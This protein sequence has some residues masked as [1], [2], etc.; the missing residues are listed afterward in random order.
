[1]I[2]RVC[3]AVVLASL[4]AVAVPGSVPASAAAPPAR[5]SSQAIWSWWSGTQAV[6]Q[7]DTT[8]WTG[9][10]ETGSQRVYRSV[11]GVTSYFTLRSIPPDDHNTPAL[12][13]EAG[14]PTVVAYTGHAGW[15]QYRAA[16]PGTL[17][18]GPEISDPFGVPT[19]YTQI[20]RRGAEGIILSRVND[21]STGWWYVT[22]ADDFQTFSEPR[23]LFSGLLD[24]GIEDFQPYMLARPFDLDPERF[25]LVLTAHPRHGFPIGYASVT[26][27]QLLDPGFVPLTLWSAEPVWQPDASGNPGQKVRVFDVGDKRGLPLVFYARW[28]DVTTIPQYYTAVRQPDGTWISTKIESSGGGF[29]D[30][31]PHYAGGIT[32]DRRSGV[33]RFYIS[34]K[35]GDGWELAT[36]RIGSTGLP[37][38]R[39][40]LDTAPVPLVRPTSVGD[41]VIYQRLDRYRTFTDFD[42]SVYQV[43][44]VAG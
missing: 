1:V 28:N 24:D 9:I 21:P 38:M 39:V 17:D 20:L 15:M 19:S 44:S 43:A 26:F 40:V 12:S 33:A 23:Q 42:S 13:V 35:T 37:Y 3:R 2:A 14:H 16:P 22:T 27:D 6:Q 4:L 10:T 36:Y 25:H 29:A 31:I 32:L 11:E 41:G 34:V 30:E 5:I 18:F 8:F 7:D